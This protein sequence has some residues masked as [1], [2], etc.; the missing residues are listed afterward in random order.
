MKTRIFSRTLVATIA[1][2]LLTFIAACQKPSGK[3]NYNKDST[4]IGGVS[5]PDKDSTAIA[6]FYALNDS[7]KQFKSEI[8]EVK[9][10]QRMWVWL[11]LAISFMTLFM[12][13]FLYL[14]LAKQVSKLDKDHKKLRLE[15]AGNRNWYKV[16][17]EQLEGSLKSI[18]Q[19]ERQKHE[20]PKRDM[21]HTETNVEEKDR[22]VPIVCPQ[23]SLE[24]QKLIY[25]D[26]P[27]G[28]HY[29]KQAE[30]S[31]SNCFL[32]EISSGRGRYSLITLDRIKSDDLP[33][34]V[35]KVSGT[36]RMQDAKGFKPVRDGEVK[37]TSENSDT[38]EIVRPVEIELY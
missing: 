2:F 38:W 4:P 20:L 3:E 24:K 29:F 6:K 37:Q 16:R 15:S 10:S 22:I 36:V 33:E 35:V 7:L 34:S 23:D 27:I 11:L 26:Q 14:M 5:A 9:S 21:L 18:G 13:I 31:S 1:V 8:A 12:A 19:A 25:F 32:V 30:R 17:M 28:G